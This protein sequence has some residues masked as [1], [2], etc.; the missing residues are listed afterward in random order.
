MNAL[1]GERLLVAWE[2]GLAV[3]RLWRPLM[4]LELAMPEKDSSAIATLPLAERNALLLE[5]RSIT[6]GRIIEAFAACPACD[7]P[8]EFALHAEDVRPASG[9][10]TEAVWFEDGVEIHM[11][12][13]NTAD[14]IAIAGACSDN[15]ACSLML[16]RTLGMSMEDL[17]SVDHSNWLQRFE[18]LN[19]PAETRCALTCGACAERSEIDFDI[20]GFLWRE[21]GTAARRL[22]AE[23]HRLA[24][25][26]GWSEHTIAAMNASRRNAYLELLNS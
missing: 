25:A 23:I 4:L 5:L 18:Q 1:S 22:M 10:P 24:S 6:F 26:Y 7:A 20:A 17:G 3:P 19:A 21:V 16:A 13:A 11:R 2:R 12:A 8:L 15:D 9:A 14:L